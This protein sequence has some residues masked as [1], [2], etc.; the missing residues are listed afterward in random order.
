MDTQRRFLHTIYATSGLIRTLEA[1]EKNWRLVAR[2]HF[3]FWRV[4]A[5]VRERETALL[6]TRLDRYTSADGEGSVTAFEE[7]T[8]R[9]AGLFLRKLST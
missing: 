4:D 5:G 9:D 6:Q 8:D 1:I 2:F 7:L 3:F